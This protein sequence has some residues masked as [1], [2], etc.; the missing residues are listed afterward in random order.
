MSLHCEATTVRYYD[1]H[2]DEY[3]RSTVG[4]DMQLLHEPFLNRIP[5]GGRILDAGCGSGRDS[6]AF[7][8]RGYT[9]VSID[10]SQK[11]VAATT[12]ITGQQALQVA[13][14]DVSLAEEFDGIWACASLLHVPLVELADVFRRLAWALRPSG[15]FY[16][17]FKDGHGE[18]H[19]DGRLFTDMDEASIIELVAGM[20]ELELVQLWHTDDLRPGRLDKWL[21]VLLR[22]VE[23]R[24]L[25]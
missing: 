6:K 12:T 15:I 7:L 20:V 22:K 9:V 8:D 19:R 4:I 17:S 3:V 16:A 18:C 2:A 5:E 21:N 1:D 25:K 13:F 24:V 10:A 23:W 11:M 14:Q